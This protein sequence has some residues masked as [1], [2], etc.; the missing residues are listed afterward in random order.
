M[1]LKEKL[2][3]KLSM[4]TQKQNLHTQYSWYLPAQS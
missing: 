2:T 3:G 4:R 1:N